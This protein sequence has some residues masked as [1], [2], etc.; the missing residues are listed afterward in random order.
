MSITS[1][2]T[3][4]DG[5]REEHSP[6]KIS[7]LKAA[8]GHLLWVD[9]VDPGDEELH[10]LQK[11]FGLHPLA[12]EDVQKH[13]QR[14]K[15]ER[16][17]THVFLVARTFEHA[18]VDVF[19]GD[20]WVLT[21]RERPPD[22][23]PWDVTEAKGR[24]ERVQPDKAT[25]GFLLYVLLDEIVDGYFIATDRAEEV[26]ET[27]EDRIFGEQLREERDVQQELFEI[28]RK[29][30]QFR[31]SVVPMRDV[32]AELLRGQVPH[33]DDVARVQL[34]DVYDHVLRAVD[35]VDSMRELMANAV[36]A[37]LAIISNRMN[38]V[39]KT[40]TSWGAIL[41]G[42]TLIAG[43]YGMNF[44]HMPELHW[45]YGYAFALGLMALLT[46]VGWRY[47]RSRDWL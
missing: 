19:W 17:P 8:G 23:E 2:A 20:G 1:C 9:A 15:I 40:M 27:I 44:D 33:I 26:L 3:Y 6:S 47:F 36:D 42:S 43:I 34:Q 12:M 11:Q 46:L 35:L 45:R 4:K 38:Q 5:E 31:R 22:G 32:V 13:Q 28:R 16:Y 29:L 39:M 25:P 18:E 37:H 7:E 30:V 41:L 14:P 24:F 21:V 10:Q